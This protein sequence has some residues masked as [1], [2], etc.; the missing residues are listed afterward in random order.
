MAFVAQDDSLQVTSTPHEAIRF[1]AKLW[2]PRST[3]DEEIE[4]LT[5]MMIT[6]LGLVVWTD[7][8]VG[9]AFIK[10][11]SGGQRKR[12]S[13]GI[14]LITKP[15]LVFLDKPTS[16]LLTLFLP[17]NCVRCSRGLQMLVR[18][19]SLPFTNLPLRSSIPSII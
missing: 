12:T 16:R 9:G 11:I 15:T 19:Y 17:F 3:T 2:L 10:G 4:T 6:K 13:A 7:T 5:R 8:I 18:V 1:A 14:E